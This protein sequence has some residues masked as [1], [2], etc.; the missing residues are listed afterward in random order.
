M[1]NIKTTLDLSNLTATSFEHQQ[2]VKRSYSEFKVF[3]T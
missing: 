2:A 1:L 3:Y